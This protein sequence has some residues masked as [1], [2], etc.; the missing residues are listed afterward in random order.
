MVQDPFTFEVI[1]V[2]GGHAG[3]EAAAAAARMGARTLLITMNLQAIGQMSCNPAIGGIGKGQLVRE[4]D[5]LGGLMGTVTDATGV[6]FRMLNR[7]KGP[8]VW[9][10][11]AQSDRMAYA[12]AVRE[13]LESLPTLFMR[14][15]MATDVLVED[16]RVVGVQTQTRQTFRAPTVILTSG[17][18][19]NGLIHI[20]ERQYGG[21]RAGERAA[22]GLTA[23]L[24]RLGFTTGRLKTGTPPRIDGRTIDYSALEAQPG[25]AHPSPFSFMTD[26]LPTEQLNCWLTYTNPDVHDALR[27]GF[28]R[29]PMFN[30][31]IQSIGPRYCPS[32]EDKINRFADKDRHQIFIEPEGRTTHEMYV[33][34]FST[35]LPEEV[36]FEA[37]RRIPGLAQVHMLRPGYA[38]EYDYFP[39]HQVRYSLETKN[40]PGLFFA[41]QINGTTGYEEAAVQ[42]LVAGINAVQYLRDAPPLVLKR[43]EAYIG[44]LIDDLV[45]K[46]TDEPYRMFTSRAEHRILL[47]QDNADLRL[48]ERGYQLGLATRA[49]YDRM[50]RKREALA[51]TMERLQNHP[52]SP[53][54][55]N[56]YLESVGTSPITEPVRLNRLVTRPQVNLSDLLDAIGGRDALI[57][58][59]EG[60]EKTETLVEIEFKYAG[61]LDREQE[62][63]DKMEQLEV[64]RIPAGFD[65]QMVTNITLEARE[66]LNKIRPENLGQASRISGVSPADISVLMILLRRG[67][68]PKVPQAPVQA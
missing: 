52:V 26:R 59:V 61:Y 11:R 6:Q 56:G 29:S 66:K 48:T 3:S 43:S 9:S 46:G 8:A 13:T 37:L 44:V 58:P 63:V 65:Y 15:D 49:R 50:L 5:A 38:I 4:V 20:G 54:S 47:R 41:G 23:S 39:P 17:T 27:T 18:F 16:G 1:V 60:I 42:G 12:A 33:N 64:L 31:T 45:A 7:R 10:P 14:M 19:L 21:G 51:L 55:V 68:K 30:G 53:A 67:G 34:G 22:T 57:V 32:I 25:D 28:D 40:V 35:S 2:G 36:Q 24:M 62:M